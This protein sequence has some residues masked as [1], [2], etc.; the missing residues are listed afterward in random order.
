MKCDVCGAVY[1]VKGATPTTTPTRVHS[2][3]HRADIMR[4]ALVRLS[5][6]V[7]AGAKDGPEAWTRRVQMI[8]SEALRKADES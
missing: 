2:G 5:T 7:H 3:E 8:A 4:A 6:E 1:V